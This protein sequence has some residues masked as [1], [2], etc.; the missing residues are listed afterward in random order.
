MRVSLAVFLLLI[1]SVFAQ[2]NEFKDA[3]ISPRPKIVF[4]LFPV[5]DLLVLEEIN[6]NRN[7]I[8]LKKESESEESTPKGFRIG[9]ASLVTSL[10]SVITSLMLL[11]L[12]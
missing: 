3:E 1:A 6:R 2:P 12:D 9:I 4:L 8:K 11:R 5:P 10:F 7:Q